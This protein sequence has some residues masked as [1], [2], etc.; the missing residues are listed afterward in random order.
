[1]TI[2]E[3]FYGEYEKTRTAEE[4]A[5]VEEEEKRIFELYEGD[6]YGFA[7]WAVEKG[8]ELEATTRMGYKELTLWVWDMEG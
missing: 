3:Y 7:E 1:M 2:R 4:W 6:D 5:K 8:I